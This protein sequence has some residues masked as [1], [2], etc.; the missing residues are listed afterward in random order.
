[1]TT[2]AQRVEEVLE[3]RRKRQPERPQQDRPVPKLGEVV[4][5]ING[6]EHVYVNGKLVSKG[7]H[8]VQVVEQ[9]FKAC[10]RCGGEH[11]VADKD[12]VLKRDDCP[13]S[14]T[15][16]DPISKGSFIPLPGDPPRRDPRALYQGTTLRLW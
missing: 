14:W 12:A 4:R 10:S 6:V 15:G 5:R 8:A 16:Q 7:G 9:H 2:P 1:M 3:R 11:P 13:Q